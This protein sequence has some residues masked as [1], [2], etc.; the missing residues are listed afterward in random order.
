MAGRDLPLVAVSGMQV[1]AIVPFGI[2]SGST[3]QIVVRRG[4]V[5]S[6]PIPVTLVPARPAIFTL[7]QG[8][9]GQGIIVDQSGQCAQ[10]GN[11]ARVGDVVVIY[12]AGLGALDRE[13]DAGGPAPPSPAAAARAAISATIAARPARVL[14]AGLTPGFAGLYQVNVVVPEGVASGDQVPAEI[15]DGLQRSPPVTMGVR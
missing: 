7:N 10:P 1:N 4:R 14:F 15:T 2:P 11:G 6:V 12:C 13:T 3:Q 8:G 5:P 9:T